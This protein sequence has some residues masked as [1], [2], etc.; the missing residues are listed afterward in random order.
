VTVG[1][2]QPLV[3]NFLESFLPR[4]YSSRAPPVA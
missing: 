3:A 4:Y 1:Y 2:V